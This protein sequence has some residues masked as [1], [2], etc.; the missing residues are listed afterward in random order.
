MVYA[1]PCETLADMARERHRL[2]PCPRDNRAAG[3]DPKRAFLAGPGTE[4]KR[5]VRPFPLVLLN[6]TDHD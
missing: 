1:W 3:F 2:A 4:A 5:Q 6:S